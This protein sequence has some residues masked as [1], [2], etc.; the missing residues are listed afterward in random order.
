MAIDIVFYN[1][2][3]ERNVI[4]KTITEIATYSCTLK[5]V[6]NV[7]TPQII[8][9][10][11]TISGNYA[12][13]ADFKR[14]YYITS[15]RTIRNG[16]WEITLECDVLMSYKTAILNTHVISGNAA[17][18]YNRLIKHS[19]PMAADNLNLYRIVDGDMIFNPAAM[20]NGTP[21]IVVTAL[22]GGSA[23]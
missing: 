11:Q 4:S 9:T 8:I 17:S 15:I 21:N 7:V 2:N 22:G 3:S 12:Y 23:V 6:V 19:I 13:I 18:N 5:D 20:S 16:I 14:Y 10:A 1:T